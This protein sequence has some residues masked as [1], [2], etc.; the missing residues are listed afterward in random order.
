MHERIGS[1]K[2]HIMAAL[3]EITIRT[4]GSQQ[5]DT[6]P[7]TASFRLPP[8]V[9]DGMVDEPCHSWQADGSHASLVG[10]SSKNDV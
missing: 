7:G 6:S 3:K 1:N 2:M 10:P 8:A 9:F 4:E 5:S